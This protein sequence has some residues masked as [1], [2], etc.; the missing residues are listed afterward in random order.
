MAKCSGMIRETCREVR[1]SL[2]GFHLFWR[3]LGLLI[4]GFAL[5]GCDLQDDQDV[6]L[7]EVQGV[8]KLD[9]SPVENARVLFLPLE[10]QLQSD[11]SLSY[12]VTD[13]EGKF[14]LQKNGL[15]SGAIEGS[16]RVFISKPITE[17]EADNQALKYQ[18]GRSVLRSLS[19]ASVPLME[20][21]NEIPLHYN[22]SS[23]LVFEVV[24]GQGVNQANFEL[25]TIDPMLEEE[26]Q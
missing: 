17:G 1:R 10:H 24:P 2:D 26:S 9:G 6:A 25:S 14:Q 16:H 7:V 3:L 21:K 4:L 19:G 20:L 15:Q 13:A 8:V 12:G 23:D 11:F 5:L 22:Q 18:E